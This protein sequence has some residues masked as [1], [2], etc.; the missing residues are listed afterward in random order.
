MASK[1]FGILTLISLF[2]LFGF[3]AYEIVNSPRNLAYDYE[4]AICVDSPEKIEKAI[5]NATDDIVRR[6]FIVIRIDT[7]MHNKNKYTVKCYGVDSSKLIE[8]D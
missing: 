6:N 3:F 4:N 7:K 5:K 2:A 8:K 1:I